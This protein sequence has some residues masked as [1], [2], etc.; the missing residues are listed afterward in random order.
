MRAANET[1]EA[2]TTKAT[3]MRSITVTKPSS[4]HAN[5]KRPATKKATKTTTTK[6]KAGMKTAPTKPTPKVAPSSMRW[7]IA[8]TSLA[9]ETRFKNP[10]IVKTFAAKTSHTKR[11]R[12][13]W[14]HPCRSRSRRRRL[15][16][17]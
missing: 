10:H 17:E 12:A 13:K 4:K 6:K 2:A 7:T 9:I 11:M 5:T 3:S 15:V 14:D 1:Q 8:L 16:N